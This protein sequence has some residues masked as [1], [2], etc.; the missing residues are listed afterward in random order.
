MLCHLVNEESGHLT[1]GVLRDHIVDLGADDIPLGILASHRF[2]KVALD[3]AVH[4]VA[5]L[6]LHGLRHGLVASCAVAESVVAIGAILLPVVADDGA[7]RGHERHRWGNSL[8]GKR[9]PVI[10]HDFCNFQHLGRGDLLDLHHV[11][12]GEPLVFQWC[13]SFEVD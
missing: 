13:H 4:I 3:V 11:V 2:D 12:L 10:L 8:V 6:V 5:D 1:V 7:A 9:A